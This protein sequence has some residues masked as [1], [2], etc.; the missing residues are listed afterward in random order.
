M[1]Y[2]AKVSCL[3][4]LVVSGA[5]GQGDRGTITGTVTDPTG[6]AVTGAKVIAENTDTHNLLET[7]TTA[8]GNFTLDQVPVGTWDVTVDA[9]G[10]KKFT[11]QRNTIEVAQTIRV[12]AALQVGANTE[13]VAVQADALAIRTEDADITSTVGNQLFVELP[14]QWTNGFYGNQAVRNPLSVA[15]LLPGMS[16]GTSYFGSQGLTA[17]GSSINGMVPGTFRA[18][19]DGQDSTSLYTPAFF[20]YQQPSVEAMEEVSLQSGNYSAEFGQAQGGIFNFT[21]KSG[22]NQ[23]HGGLF[24]RFTNE[25]LNAHQPYTGVRTRSRENNFGGTFGGPL[26][27]PHLYNGHDKT[28][29]FFSYEGFRSVLPDP[30][31]GT[32]TTVPNANDLAGNFAADLGAQV[33]CGG[34]PCKDAL[35]QA[36]YAGEI[37]DPK[38]LAADG[39]TRM[40]FPNNTIPMSR[41]DPVALKIQSYLPKFEN[42]LQALN[43][44]LG[45]VTH[46]PENL[47][48]IKIDHNFSSTLKLSTFYSYIGG[49]GST[50][51]DGLPANITNSGLNTQTSSTARVNL[52]DTIRPT[53]L[54]HWGAGYVNTQVTKYPFPEVAAF[55]QVSQLGLA[56]AVASGFPFLSGLGNF[57]A[58]GGFIGGMAQSIGA[59]YDQAPNTGEFSSSAALTWVKGSHTF[60]FGGSMQT[61]ME[62][63]NACQGG[64]GNYTFSAAQTGQPFGAGGVALAT[65][66]GTPGLGYASFLLGLPS[67]VTVTPCTSVNWHDR[68]ISE[69]AQ[70]NWKVTR[71]LTLDV[72]LRYDLQNPPI[73]DR[74]RDSSFSPT[75]PNPSAGYLPGA[76]LY[77][78]SGADTCNCSNFLRLYKFAFGPRLGAAYQLTPKTVIR[79]GWGFFYG[80]P[81][82]FLASAPQFPAVGTGYDT[83]TFLPPSTGA[84]ALPNGLQGGLV[85]NPALFS[86]TL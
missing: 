51:T 48:S 64:W 47:P 66:N 25:D 72:G 81:E 2:L 37:Y 84:S 11:S 63:F 68:A 36:V 31:S 41:M 59:E 20:F 33:S 79:A 65:I 67:S 24:Y 10:F 12:D 62:G 40:P 15:Q 70:D 61:R 16:G 55:N 71:R 8:T 32:F 85:F 80:G 50:S 18:L 27:I 17:G 44:Q 52:D 54:L 21:P 53:V 26:R 38:S 45:K 30:S 56:G 6:A 28:F 23:Y 77:Q 42:G 34:G 83:I 43:F 75:A 1:R 73:E 13:T 19:V 4:A 46:R 57:S 86:A 5:F 14:I 35:G 3:F 7:V 69:Y 58:S 82:T 29:F 39:F 60:K 78:G 76:V 74:N 9:Q 22:T 49:S